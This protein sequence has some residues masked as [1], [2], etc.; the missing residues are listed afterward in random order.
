MINKEDIFPLAI[1]TY[2][3]G[4]SRSES[5]EDNNNELVID[6]EEMK[7][8][9]YS[10]RQGQNFIETS[11]IYAGGQTMKFISE[12]LKRVDRNKLFI[13]VKIENFIEKVEDIEEQLDKYLNILGIEYAD[14]ILL[15]TPKASKI[16][17]EESYRE[18]KRLVSIGKSINVSASNLNINQLKMIV[19]EIGI[20]LF[21]FEGLY[22]L[23]CKQNEDV[24]IL[25]YCKKHNILFIN[26]QPFRRNRTVN[27]NYPLL[28]ELA[29]KYNKTQNQILLN[30][31]VKEKNIIP[32]TKAN[33]MEHIKLNLEALDFDMEQQDYQ[34][35]NDFRCEEFDKLEVDWLD[36]GGIPIYKFANQVE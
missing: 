26:Y 13:T 16:P 34:R 3:L 7:S 18:L 28:V 5:W 22:N 31:Y 23:E 19:E 33:K 4:A 15:H 27:H 35:L 20:E 36:N 21:S 32:I 25:E 9:I 14:S 30:Y 11:Y 12:F 29:N 10:Y 17:L 8:L 2:G 24:G 1:G 6:E